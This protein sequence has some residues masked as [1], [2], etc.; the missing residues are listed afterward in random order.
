M[1]SITYRGIWEKACYLPNTAV[2]MKHTTNLIRGQS[3]YGKVDWDEKMVV[4]VNED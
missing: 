4:I 2:W 3:T 1:K